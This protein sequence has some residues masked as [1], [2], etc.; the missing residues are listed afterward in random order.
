MLVERFKSNLMFYYFHQKPI[1]LIK[2]FL[3]DKGSSRERG[4]ENLTVKYLNCY[5]HSN[6]YVVLRIVEHLGQLEERIHRK[7]ILLNFS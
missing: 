5:R 7:R 4:K 1:V 6:I 3:L 2:K